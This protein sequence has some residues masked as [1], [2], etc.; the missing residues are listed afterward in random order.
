MSV[1][2]TDGPAFLAVWFN[3]GSHRPI[4][5]QVDKDWRPSGD[6]ITL[7]VI[8]QHQENGSYEALDWKG[9]RITGEPIDREIAQAY[10]DSVLQ[11]VKDNPCCEAAAGLRHPR[12]QLHAVS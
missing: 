6:T 1:R 4:C 11:E 3:T 12:S 7:Y 10:L 2:F 8:G 9:V 5:C